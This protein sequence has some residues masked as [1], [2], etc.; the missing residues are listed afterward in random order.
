M[1]SANLFEA[2]TNH[3]H[4][5]QASGKRVLFALWTDG[6]RDRM[7][8]MLAD[9]K[10]MNLKNVASWPEA[11]ALPRHETARV[12]LAL[13]SGFETADLAVISET[14]I[15]GDRLVRSR[16]RRRPETSWPRRRLAAGDLV[17]HIDH[18]IGRYVG[19][20]DAARCR[21]RRTIASR[22]TTPA[23]PSS[24]LPVENIDLLT[25][26]GSDG[27]GVQLDRL[28]GAA[29]QARKARAKER[30]REMAEGLIAIAAARLR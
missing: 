12:V 28:G 29:W 3:A 15:L 16:R 25:R 14:D 13:N 19:L 26:Y 23:T 17:V 2:A 11:L 20:E 1:A 9:H 8:S 6:S 30:L 22:S 10:L 24:I 5:L 27:E 21:T 7:A 4:G 18:G